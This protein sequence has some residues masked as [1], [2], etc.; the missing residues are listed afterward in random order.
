MKASAFRAAALSRWVMGLLLVTLSLP[1]WSL[2]IGGFSSARSG[3]GSLDDGSSGALRSSLSSTLSGVSFSSADTLTADYLATVDVLVLDVA[4][5]CCAAM[6]P[7]SAEEQAA[8]RAYVDAGG[9]AVIFADNADFSASAPATNASVLDPFGVT[10]AGTLFGSFSATV[11]NPTHPV[12][13]GP[14]G[15]AAVFGYLFPG[16]FTASGLNGNP[17]A[18]EV[19]R[20][21]ANNGVAI[22]AFEHGAFG[23]G[24]GAVVLFSDDLPKFAA[25]GTS[26]NILAVNAVA[27]A[28]PVPLPAAGWLFGAALGGLGYLRRRK[29]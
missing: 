29:F 9:G 25:I 1:S 21:D 27:F 15:T 18:T 17:L 5:S 10:V 14:A 12:A 6:A 22:L 7:L 13:T 4:T 19:A 8:L 20:I 23:A 16:T 3:Q 26:D 11:T 28:Q 24:S 2:T